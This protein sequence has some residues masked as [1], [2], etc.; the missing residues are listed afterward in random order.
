METNRM[1]IIRNNPQPRLAASVAYGD[2]L[3]TVANSR[4]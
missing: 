2:L 3:G 1:T 4:W